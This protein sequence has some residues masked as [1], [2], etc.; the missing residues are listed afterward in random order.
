M[1]LIK[2]AEYLINHSLEKLA[3]IMMFSNI[4]H[5]APLKDKTITAI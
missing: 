1:S 5:I 2:F 3:E 4:I